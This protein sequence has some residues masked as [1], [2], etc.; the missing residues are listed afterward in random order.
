MP[1]TKL[2]GSTTPMSSLKSGLVLKI[3]QPILTK[4]GQVIVESIVEEAKTDAAKMGFTQGGH[5]FYDSFKFAVDGAELLIYCDWDYFVRETK[6][7]KPCQP[8]KKKETVTRIEDRTA[9]AERVIEERTG[10]AARPLEPKGP[11]AKLKVGISDI[12]KEI[13]VKTRTGSMMLK[14]AP[15]THTVWIHP[16]LCK[17]TFFT[18]GFLKAAPKC[19]K[20]MFPLIGKAL[21]KINPFK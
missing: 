19:A 14:V 9:F 6:P 8:R 10:M 4:M 15:C 12:S 20:L 7:K 21:E 16:F 3:P 17:H 11:V 2:G 13:P 1:V 18:R 5:T